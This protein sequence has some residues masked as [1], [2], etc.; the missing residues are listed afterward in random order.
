MIL[1]K[2]ICLLGTSG[3]GKTSLIARF[4]DNSFSDRYLTS[5]GVAI[6]KK[7]VQ[8]D[9]TEVVLTIWDLA[10]DDKFQPLESSYL[11][12]TSGILMV[13][14]GTRGATLDHVLELRTRHADILA[15]VPSILL[16]L[17]KADLE[18]EWQIDQARVDALA[19]S[20]FTIIKTS[21]KEGTGV[22]E[23]FLQLAQRMVQPT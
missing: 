22:Q 2:K 16:L 9:G 13:A 12:G 7:T 15:R 10:G 23:A 5:V 21:A 19:A 6:K 14:D 11:R 1:Q 8:I 20:G 3:V 17:N 18:L 4:V